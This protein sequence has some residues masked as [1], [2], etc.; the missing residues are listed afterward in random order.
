MK[1]SIYTLL[2]FFLISSLVVSCDSSTESEDD[3]DDHVH[4][5]V[6]LTF[7][8]MFGSSE[9][10]LGTKYVT[11]AGDTV[12][13]STL[14][15]YIS[16]VALVDSFGVDHH[17]DGIYM[18]DF[19][20]SGTDGKVTV[21]LE[22][23]AGTYRGVKFSV[24]VP[25]S[26]NHKDASTQSSPLGTASGMYWSWNP[27]YIFHKIEGAVDSVGKSIAIS[28]HVGEDARKLPVSLASFT[29][30][31]TTFVVEAG[32]TSTFDVLVDY[33]KLFNAGIN[34]ANKLSPKMNTTERI[35][36]VGPANL[37]DRI[38]LNSK[39]LFSRKL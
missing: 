19:S 12:S 30:T 16:E 3:D 26:E 7:D 14:K 28:Y 29:G 1:K 18:V 22:G 32:K 15:F 25:Y 38:F 35:H 17:L 6:N 39:S 37:A 8:A 4:T 2:S 23:E 24:G 34:P 9:L 13:F 21:E 5:H 11:G 27:G 10:Q 33:S 31:K 36:H 20:Q